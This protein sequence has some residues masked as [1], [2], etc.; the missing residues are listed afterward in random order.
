MRV[1]LT[2]IMPSVVSDPLELEPPISPQ[3]FKKKYLVIHMLAENGR[4]NLYFFLFN[5]KRDWNG[6]YGEGGSSEYDIL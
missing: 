3:V 2:L 4:K 6:L 5:F 1:K